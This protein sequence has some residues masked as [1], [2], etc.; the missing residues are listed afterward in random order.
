[1]SDFEITVRVNMKLEDLF[2]YLNENNFI[3]HQSFRCIDIFMIK[4]EQLVNKITLNDLNN[5]IILRKLI[6]KDKTLKYM[7]IKNK[8]YD[9]NGNIIKSNQMNIDIQYVTKEKSRLLANGYVELIKMNDHCYTYSKN[10]HEFIIEHIDELG[11]FIEFE[12]MNYDSNTKNGNSINDL[13]ELFNSF[14][15]D[16]DHNDYFCKKSWL[17]IKKQKSQYIKRNNLF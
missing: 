7:V 17:L 5:C 2:T 12:N 11:T 9:E 15:I 6:F 16:Y 1:M 14:N 13:I 3:F 10:N 4:K 8:E